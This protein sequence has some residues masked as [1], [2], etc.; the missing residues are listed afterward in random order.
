M[1]QYNNYIKNRKTYAIIII[2]IPTK[3]TNVVDIV[4]N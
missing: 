1:I 2:L 4:Y 3:S